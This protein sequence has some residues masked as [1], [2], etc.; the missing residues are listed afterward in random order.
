MTTR[1][2]P[3]CMIVMFGPPN[4]GKGT[5]GSR[6]AA[7]YGFKF[8]VAGDL[9]R[10]QLKTDEGWFE[11]R[12]SWELYDKGELVPGD[13]MGKLIREKI[14]ATGGSCVLDGYPRDE[15][16]MGVFRELGFPFILVHADQPDDVLI[17]RALSRM[18]CTGCGKVYNR[19]NPMMQPNAD[20]T[21]VDC[22]AEVKVRS[23]DNEGAVRKRLA[24]Y[25]SA[26]E[27]IL[28][29]LRS[30]TGYC[31]EVEPIL[32]KMEGQTEMGP[33]DVD[34]VASEICNLIE[35]WQTIVAGIM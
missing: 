7:H 29:E 21:C 34:S 22:G 5:Y 9:V 15:Y 11:G 14:E 12:Y 17:A 23:D 6:I 2:P 20:G 33:Q 13:L 26:T 32:E 1:I 16:Q 35:T 27:P 24:K 25:R 8:I 18:T 3:Q 4:S 10:E 28:P 19:Q 30:L 31:I